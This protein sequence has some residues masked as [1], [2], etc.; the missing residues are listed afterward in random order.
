MDVCGNPQV[1]RL[2]GCDGNREDAIA[3]II[4]ATRE[5]MAIADAIFDRVQNRLDSCTAR[6]QSIC[7]RANE[8]AAKINAIQ[9]TEKSI[10]FV[11]PA[12]FPHEVNDTEE[13][14]FVSQ[15]AKLPQSV[16]VE[17]A[18]DDVSS[19]RVPCEDIKTIIKNKSRC[20][21]ISKNKSNSFKKLVPETRNGVPVDVASVA[22]LLIYNSSVS[23]Y[24]TSQSV[25]PLDNSGMRIKVSTKK[26]LENE[27][28]IMTAEDSV[29]T[30]NTIPMDE[31]D[32]PLVYKPEIGA[33]ADF[34]F[35]D[36][37]PHLPGIATDVS[38]IIPVGGMSNNVFNQRNQSDPN[39]S[40]TNI[41]QTISTSPSMS[42]TGSERTTESSVDLRFNGKQSA[43]QETNGRSK[44]TAPIFEPR[45]PGA[46]PPPP[47]PCPPP[48]ANGSKLSNGARSAPTA[49]PPPPPGPPPTGAPPP[50]PPPPPPAPLPSLPKLPTSGDARSN[51]LEAIRAAGGTKGAKLKKVE[52]HVHQ[53]E[54]PLA[55][56]TKSAPA[57]GDLMSSLQKALELRRRGISGRKTEQ[58]ERKARQPA[59]NALSRISEL[60]P[61]PPAKGSDS[62]GSAT[63]DDWK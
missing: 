8:A 20:C 6:V 35:P 37:L 11:S 12:R 50:P 14:L 57:G 31:A 39:S 48:M 18:N 29:I 25:D 34:D 4:K 1:V 58:D 3:E 33:L 56:T 24:G 46:A 16:S 13:A 63:D 5:T 60:I 52:S 42:I 47:P 32:D 15:V 19:I 23:A 26:D 7:S 27:L 2:V 21:H 22:D 17:T 45:S 41:S 55:S 61:P 49:P 9:T 53:R 54:E 38:F 30:S 43:K 28:D 40:G 62:E 59:S 36:V 51:L 44:P 10:C